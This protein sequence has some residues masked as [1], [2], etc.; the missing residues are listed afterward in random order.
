SRDRIY[1]FL[2][3][4]GAV[5]G[6]V[7]CGERLVNEMRANHEL[8]ILETL[9]LGH[10]YLAA[11]L[12]SANL[13]GND[14]LSLHIECSGPIKG[15]DVEANA[16]GEI[17]GYLKNVPIPIEK[18]L[19]DFNLSP[20]FGAGI[21]KVTRYL[22]SAKQPF[23]G[24]VAM[25]YGTIGKDLAHYFLVSEQIPTSFNLSVQ[26]DRQGEVTGAGGLFLQVM[27]NASE[28]NIARLE[29]MVLGLPSIGA[30]F[31]EGRKPEDLVRD[32]FKNFSPKIIGNHRIEFMCHCNAD[33]TRSL[34][35][36][37]P[38]DDLKDI[39]ENG[40]FPLEMRCHHCNTSYQFTRE[41]VQK[42]YASRFP[43]N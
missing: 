4:D 27:P 10:A 23:S 14:R 11:G 37:L 7:I 18:P 34:L 13:K 9:V 31:A 38:F 21:L 25:Q 41:D 39:R 17:R 12:M 1:N 32:A 33:R 29:P 6:A 30:A 2:L 15:L 42:I 8:G 3:D 26:F 40:P 20:F 43:N 28:E 36:M 22:E 5:R 35:S 16:F 19:E 24:H